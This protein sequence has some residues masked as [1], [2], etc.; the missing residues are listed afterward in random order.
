[1]W[2][3]VHEQ[4]S[5]ANQ[6]TDPRSWLAYWRRRIWLL[7]GKLDNEEE[8][9]KFTFPII[10]THTQTLINIKEEIVKF[11]ESLPPRDR[12][13]F[14]HLLSRVRSAIVVLED[15]EKKRATS[16]HM[17]SACK[18]LIVRAVEYLEQTL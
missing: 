12:K 14:D 18:R 5:G 4:A 8:R 16:D 10:R 9:A 1:M 3:V 6:P 17:N 2:N 13:V 7:K 15:A 11:K